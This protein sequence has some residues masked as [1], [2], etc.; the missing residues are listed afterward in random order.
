MEDDPKLVAD[1]SEAIATIK[2]LAQ[3]EHVMPELMSAQK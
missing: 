3:A 1:V 2:V